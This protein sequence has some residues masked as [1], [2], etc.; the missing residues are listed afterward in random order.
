MQLLGE[1]PLSKSNTNVV[2]SFLFHFLGNYSNIWPTTL[3]FYAQVFNPLGLHLCH[4]SFASL[5]LNQGLMVLLTVIWQK[6]YF[7]SSLCFSIW[8]V[9]LKQLTSLGYFHANC[10]LLCK[11]IHPKPLNLVLF[12]R[13]PASSTM[14]SAYLSL[15]LVTAC[16]ALPFR[17]SGFLDFMMDEPGSGVPDATL[18]PL[19][20]AMP[21]MPKCPFRCQCHLRVVQCSDLGKP[22]HDFHSGFL[23]DLISC[24]S[25]FSK[26]GAWANRC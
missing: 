6:P 16:W 24:H 3:N 19:I 9:N 26:S 4:L 7:L 17:Q 13:L 2:L 8:A 12:Y 25:T 21:V 14:R 22:M 18:E 15:L 11:Q 20:P 10:K 1:N 23:H 5:G